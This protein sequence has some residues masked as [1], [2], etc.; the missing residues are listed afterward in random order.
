MAVVYIWRVIEVAYFQA[1]QNPD[2]TVRE[3][4]I[5]LLAVTWIAALANVYFGLNSELPLSLSSA[6]AD[7]LTGHLP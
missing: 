7:L 5:E 3:A 1:P 2:T 6:A 4:P